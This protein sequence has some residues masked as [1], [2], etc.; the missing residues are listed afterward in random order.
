MN[1]QET[2]PER[3]RVGTPPA[4]ARRYY[5]HKNVRFA[6]APSS[7]IRGG[8]TFQP[9]GREPLHFGTWEETVAAVESTC[10]AIAKHRADRRSR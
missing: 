1:T 6:L 4:S 3:W 9:F 10:A 7:V 2:E 5:E 8:W